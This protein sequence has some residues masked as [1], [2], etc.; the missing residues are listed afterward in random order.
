MGVMIMPG[1]V[2]K[3]IRSPMRS[4]ETSSESAMEG[5]AG[6][7]DETPMTAVSVIPKMMYRFTS[8][9]RGFG[10]ESG[11]EVKVC[12]FVCLD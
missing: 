8:L 4:V 11:L 9:K 3:V 10:A 7:M 1:I 6:A 12:S 2:K 5:K